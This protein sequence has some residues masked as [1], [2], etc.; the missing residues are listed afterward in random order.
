M[1]N[2]IKLFL[3]FFF[4]F[5]VLFFFLSA[6]KNSVS[7]VLFCWMLFFFCL[8]ACIVLL[9]TRKTPEKYFE[10]LKARNE[11]IRKRWHDIKQNE[12]KY[13]KAVRHSYGTEHNRKPNTIIKKINPQQLRNSLYLHNT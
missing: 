10:E 11:V 5:F 12:H 4:F 7:I 9:K 3:W 2:I 1:L 13:P 8:C 6:K